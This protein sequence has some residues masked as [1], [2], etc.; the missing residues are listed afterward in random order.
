MKWLPPNGSIQGSAD[1]RYVVVHATENTWI[2]YDISRTTQFAEL[3]TRSSDS[4]A[5]ALCEAA[6]RALLAQARKRA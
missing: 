6:E 4:D 1:G 5:R 3:G 2:A